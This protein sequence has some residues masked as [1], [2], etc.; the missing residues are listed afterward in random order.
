MTDDDRAQ[1]VADIA[2]AIHET[3]PSPLSS[4]ETQWVR[5]A[6]KREARSMAFREAVIRH[7][8]SGLVLLGVVG[9]LAFLGGLIG[10]Y[11]SAHGWKR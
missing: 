7:T 11:A 6:I 10:D 9:V 2:A 3:M 8:T 4:E 1:F 5:M